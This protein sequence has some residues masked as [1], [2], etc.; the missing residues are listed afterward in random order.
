MPSRAAFS[1]ASCERLRGYVDAD[2][3]RV[4]ALVLQRKRDRTGTDADVQ[5]ARRVRPLEQRERPLDE[6]LGLGSRNERACVGLQRQPAKA[7]LAEHVGE[8]LARFA[9]LEERP[10]G[11]VHLPFGVGVEPAARRAEDMCEEELGVDARRVDPGGGEPLLRVAERLLQLHAE[12][13]SRRSSAASASVNS[14]SS[15]CRM[16]SSWCTVSLMR[17][18]VSRFS[19]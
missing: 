14:S 11:A 16:R 7:P 5:H 12:R 18:S 9:S 17:W 1:R 3:L 4:G 15:P 2:D 13:S 10:P 8:R 6:D 19:G